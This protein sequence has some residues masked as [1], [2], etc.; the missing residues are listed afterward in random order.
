MKI[1]D[2]YLV[3]EMSGPFLFGVLAFVLLF[4]SAN[5]LLELT[6]LIGELGI[7][8]WTASELF[9]LRLPRFVV[10]TLPLATLVAMLI[11]FGRLSGDSEL[12][13]MYAGG[14][15]F[16]RL[17]VPM[18]A[19]GLVV[20]LA[21]FALNELVVPT[22][23]W[24]AEEI[25]RNAAERA[26]R[27]VK[28]IVILPEMD[29]PNIARV[30]IADQ[31]N[32]ASGEM[33]HPTIIWFVKGRAATATTAERGRWQAGSWWLYQ[34]SHRSL[35]PDQLASAAFERTVVD[36]HTSPKTMAEQAR[37]PGDMTYRE[38][39]EYIRYMLRQ[40]LPTTELELTLQQKLAI[41]LASL[42]FALIAPPLGLRSHRGGS[43]I[44]LGIAILIG[45]AYYVVAMYLSQAA[46][47]GHLTALWAAWLPD[48]ATGAVGIGLILKMRT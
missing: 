2:R 10:Y 20:S 13:A 19:A 33:L 23:N 42:V 41:P 5:I 39:R 21:T 48:M 16:R 3:R 7:S 24:R 17:V 12:V 8:L 40:R 36:F 4:V 22:S 37:S 14:V 9:V 27:T 43:A 45:F 15:R 18:V 35:R 11:T 28:R 1:L 31:L 6:Q 25:V 46:V 38:L 26:G 32:V 29:G 47:Q 34:G 30:V 44:G